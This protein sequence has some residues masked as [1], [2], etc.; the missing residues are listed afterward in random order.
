MKKLIAIAVVFA[1]IAGTA[2]ADTSISGS[3]DIRFWAIEGN[4]TGRHPSQPGEGDGFNPTTRGEISAAYLQFSGQ[5]ESQTVGAVWRLRAHDVMKRAANDE[6]GR[7]RPLFHRTFIWWKPIPQLR[8][9]LGMDADGMYST[10][11]D[12]FDWAFHQGPEAFLAVHDWDLWRYVFPGH[13]DGFGLSFNIYPLQGLNINLTIPTGI[14]QSHTSNPLNPI[15]GDVSAGAWPFAQT[16]QGTQMTRQWDHVFFAGL[17][18]QANFAIPDIGKIWFAYDGPGAAGAYRTGWPPSGMQPL[19]PDGANGYYWDGSEDQGKYGNFGRI[20]ASFELT[21]VPGLKAQ[22]GIS[23]TLLG[24]EVASYAP[25]NIGVG[26]HYVGGDWGVK[27]R[28]AITILPRNT[29]AGGDNPTIASFM[30]DLSGGKDYT[31]THIT[32]NIMPWYKLS[33]MTVYCD[34]GMTMLTSDKEKFS[35]NASNGFGWWVTPYAKV[36]LGGPSLEFGVQVYSSTNGQ[37]GL[38]DQTIHS[39]ADKDGNDSGGAFAGKPSQIKYAIPLRL[40]FNF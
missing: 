27:V 8:V 24:S 19:S 7:E 26:A 20:G 36:P 1:L 33:F 32:A 22:L 5:N 29:A 2:F 10:G 9:F 16:Q 25:F 4:D 30:G 11:D 38:G 23:T 34:I 15:N 6:D 3:L 37:L 12:I 40:V 28:S 14:N 31:N 17:K 13:W 18:L 39:F 21:A 35:D